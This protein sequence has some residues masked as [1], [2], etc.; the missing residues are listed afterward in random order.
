MSTDPMFLRF[1]KN[2]IDVAGIVESFEA[3]TE[4]MASKEASQSVL[5]NPPDLGQFRRDFCNCLRDIQ[6]N[7][8]DQG[9]V[10]YLNSYMQPSLEEI[11]EEDAHVRHATTQ[12]SVLIKDSEAPWVEA[13][14]CY[15]LTLFIK[16]FGSDIIKCCAKCNKF[17][18]N[19]GKYAKY[20]SDAC[21][22]AGGPPAAIS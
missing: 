21:K 11:L 3:S 8:P 6:A 9:V 16:G 10:A 20:C 18:S 13:L 19:K 5:E 12:R 17:F 22:N 4:D 1:A 14:V 7:G 15:N 2:R